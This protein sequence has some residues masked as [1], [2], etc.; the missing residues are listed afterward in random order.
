MAQGIHRVT[1]DSKAGRKLISTGKVYDA[2][3]LSYEQQQWNKQVELKR[4]LKKAKQKN[5]LVPVDMNT[6]ILPVPDAK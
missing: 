4:K 5:W 6:Q 2:M 3:K 1:A